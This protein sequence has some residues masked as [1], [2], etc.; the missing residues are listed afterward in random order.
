MISGA[1]CTLVL[2][3]AV[4]RITAAKKN[5]WENSTFREVEDLPW[6]VS[7]NRYPSHGLLATARTLRLGDRKTI[8]SLDKKIKS[9]VTLDNTTGLRKTIDHHGNRLPTSVLV[10]HS[11]TNEYSNSQ[12]LLQDRNHLQSA[13][14]SSHFLSTKISSMQEQR[15]T[16]TIIYSFLDHESNRPGKISPKNNL[17]LSHNSSKVAWII[18]RHPSRILYQFHAFRK[19]SDSKERICLSE[20]HKER[21]EREAYCNS[22][23]AVNGIIHDVDTLSKGTQLLT[24]LV[25]SGGLYKM[26]RLYI[27]PDGFFFRV[28]ILA[29]DNLNCHK[30]CLDFK[31]GSRYIIMGQIYHK[32]MELPLSMQQ[33]ISGRLRAGDG[34]VTSGSNFVKRFNRKKERKVLAAM[35]SKCQ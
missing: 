3:I 30:S 11:S 14:V 17:D 8:V 2:F 15:D 6:R 28:K 22:D 29:V 32:R 9:K 31:L 25:N 4:A 10:E 7:L 35:H 19:E 27:T 18:N 1:V 21:D 5:V 16:K 23:F 26:N 34:L 33:T 13:L 12:K 20:C 24:I